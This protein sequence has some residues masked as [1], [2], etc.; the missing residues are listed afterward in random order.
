MDPTTDRYMTAD[1][2]TVTTDTGRFALVPEWVLTL[3]ISDKALRLYALLSVRWADR[4]TGEC[5]PSRRTIADALGCSVDTV[6]RATAELEA[7]EAITVHR[8]RDEDGTNRPNVYVI[9]RIPATSGCKSAARGSGKSAARGSGKSAPTS[10]QKS[11]P[12]QNQ[13]LEP[14]EPVLSSSAETAPTST[15]SDDRASKLCDFF[16]EQLMAA[17]PHAKQPRITKQW[18]AEADRMLRLDKRDPREVAAVVRW[19]FADPAGAFWIANCRSVPTL[20]RQY[21]KL[22]VQMTSTKRPRTTGAPIV[23]RDELVTG[24]ISI[25]G[26]AA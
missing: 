5:W 24:R 2:V 19:I 17:D 16:V 6:T 21:D 13:E 26:G 25:A 22:R 1:Q 14:V 10:P 8:R 15:P 23:G 20:R 4:D 11:V 12:N 9:H 3:P 18:L 7:V